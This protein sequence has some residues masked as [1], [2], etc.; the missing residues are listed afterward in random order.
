MIEGTLK[1]GFE[2]RIPDENYDDYELFED[3]A[4]IDEDPN[5]I[6]KMVSVFKRLLGEE[7][8][9]AL[10]EHMRQENGRIRTTQME[11]V[12]REI[13]EL[14]DESKNSEPSPT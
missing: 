2:I 7:Q 3:L 4:A 1:S 13:F 5:N 9:N 6:G 10:K 8:Y 12:L 14:N 11:K